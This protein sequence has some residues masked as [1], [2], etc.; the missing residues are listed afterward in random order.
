MRRYNYERN[1]WE[2]GRCIRCPRWRDPYSNLYC[3]KHRCAH[4]LAVRRYRAKKKAAALAATY[5]HRREET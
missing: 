5:S 1:N 3:P 2:T 4:L